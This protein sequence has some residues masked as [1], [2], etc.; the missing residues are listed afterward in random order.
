MCDRFEHCLVATPT[1]PSFP[2][3]D[4]R[5]RPDDLCDFTG[6]RPFE[7]IEAL[8][9]QRLGAKSLRQP[10]KPWFDTHSPGT[11]TK[12]AVWSGDQWSADWVEGPSL[13]KHNGFWYLFL[14][15]GN[16]NADYTIRMG[17]SISPTGPYFDK[18]GVGLLEYD[19]GESRHGNS[20]LLGDEGEYLVPGHP[21]LWNENSTYYMGYDYRP[22][23]T[24]EPDIMGIRRLYWVNDWPTI[25]TP[26][27][28]TFNANDHLDAV[29][30]TLGISMRNSGSGS[31]AAFDHVTL[32]VT[33]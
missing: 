21:H 32:T 22:N 17:R 2:T 7:P 27:T 9:S 23:S 8:G 1:L 28:V 18:D 3:E 30:Q 20:I 26:I 16:M 5:I 6:E 15:C 25:W 12:V 24:N 10:T 11:H 31:T 14:T 33:H 13:C 4:R 19:S 29:G